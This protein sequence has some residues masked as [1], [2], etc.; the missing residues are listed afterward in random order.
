VVIL[1]GACG[2]DVINYYAEKLTELGQT[3]H[4]QPWACL[5]D[6]KNF[7]A[8]TAEAQRTIVA[9]YDSCLKSGCCLKMNNSQN[10]ICYKF[11][12]TKRQN[13]TD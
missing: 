5:C 13:T 3:Y 10:P 1:S 4:G 9:A 12:K 8:T 2:S 7:Q 6:G 11:S